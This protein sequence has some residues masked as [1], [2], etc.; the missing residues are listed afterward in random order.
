MG[1]ELLAPAGSKDALQAAVQ[2]GADAVYLGL[3]AF[4]ARQYAKNF[5]V[6]SLREAAV[7]CH[8]R[9]VQIHVAMNTLIYDRELP[10]AVQLASEA[11]RAGADALIIQDLGFAKV[12]L[13]AGIPIPL[14]A[15]TQ[16]TIHNLEG[17][18]FAQQTGF[19]RVVLARELPRSEIETISREIPIETEVFVHGALCM[20]Y[21]GQCLLSSMIGGRSGNRGRCAQPCRLP[22]TML[23]DGKNIGQGYWMSPKDLRLGA[24]IP[25]LVAMG[26]DSLKIEGRMK[27]AAY[28]AA[29]T[30]VYRSC[31]DENRA[32]TPQEMQLLQNVFSRDRF[33]EAFYAGKT[34]RGIMKTESSNDD[35][36][37]KQNP[38]LLKALQE[39]YAPGVENRRKNMEVSIQIRVGTPLT[40]TARCKETE[41]ICTG[42]VVQQATGNPVTR[43]MVETQLRK[44]G[45]SN[46]ML[47]NL[48]IELE[49]NAFVPK[50]ALNAVRREL[51]EQLETKIGTHGQK[52]WNAVYQPQKSGQTAQ[53]NMAITVWTETAAQ[54]AAFADLPVARLYVPADCIQNMEISEQ[55]VAYFP[56]ILREEAMQRA[57]E[58]LQVCQQRGV[59][60]IAAGNVGLL[61]QAK[62]MGFSLIGTADLNVGNA[63]AAA[64]WKNFGLET[65]E[66]SRELNLRGIE[67]LTGRSPLAVEVTGY[68]KTALMKIENCLVQVAKNG[69]GCAEGKQYV[70]QDRKGA[71]MRVARDGCVSTVYNSVPVY[72]ADRMQA[73]RRSGVSAVKLV[74]TEES[75]QQCLEIYQEF[76]SGEGAPPQHYTRGHF[77]RGAE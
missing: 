63:A 37:E 8:L 17:A 56:M 29:A 21:S 15:S 11:V 19:R 76:V 43:E 48:E 57:K 46:F 68:G 33:T 74:F 65:V 67:A 26:A 20:S 70:L 32:I 69:C 42:Q 47:Q 28:V 35:I 1:I 72:M 39:T 71:K 18:R 2:N 66:V 30:K 60:K 5:D 31:I 50:S 13:E 16:M 3:Q 61:L 23:E 55:M 54:A 64:F 51:V 40:A 12:L 4:G 38:Q 24:Y 7:Y 14:H 36:Y 41:V 62:E 49:E 27:S 53:K 58:Q 59:R 44:L 22:Y 6:E 25:E 9:D 75:P 52:Q 77:Y 34:G 73:L 45:G 10:Q